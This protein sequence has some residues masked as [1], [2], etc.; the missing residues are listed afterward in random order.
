MYRESWE[1]GLRAK[2]CQPGNGGIEDLQGFLFYFKWG[3]EQKNAA[4]LKNEQ[5][6]V[7]QLLLLT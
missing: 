1:V 3:H 2:G 7:S 6:G 4:V 5:L